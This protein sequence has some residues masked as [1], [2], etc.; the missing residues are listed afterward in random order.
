MAAKTEKVR[1]KVRLT[2]IRETREKPNGRRGRNFPDSRAN[3]SCRGAGRFPPSTE[4]MCSG[5]YPRR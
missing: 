4:A 3:G 1:R 5:L 2:R